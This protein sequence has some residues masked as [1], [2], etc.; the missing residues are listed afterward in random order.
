MWLPEHPV[1]T[2]SKFR[3]LYLGNDLQ[4]IA[5]VRE[6]LNES[7]YQLVACSDHGGATLFL[8]SDIRYDALVIDYEWLGSEGLKL[9]ELAQSLE[10]RRGMPILVVAPTQLISEM[11]KAARKAGMKKCVTKSEDMAAVIDA[12]RKLPRG[13][14]R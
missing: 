4:L 3:F 9:V 10:H 13:Q 12:I 14:K 5:A 11:R 1:S 2:E 7:D 6:A 8:K